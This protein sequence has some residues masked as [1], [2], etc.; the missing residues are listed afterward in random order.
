MVRPE[1]GAPC[2]LAA[3]EPKFRLLPHKAAGSRSFV[4]ETI[5]M[6]RPEIALH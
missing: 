1:N 4:N 5:P 2:A 6:V 3:Q